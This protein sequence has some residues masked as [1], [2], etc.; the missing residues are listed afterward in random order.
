MYY[1]SDFRC[2]LFAMHVTIPSLLLNRFEEIASSNGAQDDEE[3]EDD[4]NQA[5]ESDGVVRSRR[6]K[7]LPREHV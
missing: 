1:I 6:K 3:E 2:S 7:K 5:D 4:D